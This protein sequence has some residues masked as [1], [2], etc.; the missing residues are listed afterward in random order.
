MIEVIREKCVGCSACL[1]ACAY[2]AITIED[3]LAEID[4]DKCTLCGACVSACPFDA[5]IVRRFT[6]VE[7]NKD[8]YKG[9]WVFAEQRVNDI[10]P[11]VFELLGKGRELADTRE[12]EL[13]AVL[14]GYN[15]KSLADKLIA[16][17]ADKVIIVDEPELEYFTDLA[18]AKAMEELAVKHKPEII[19]SG[20]TNLGRSFIPR[21]AVKLNTGLTADC[22]SLE[23]DPESSNLMQTRPAFGGNIMA[24]ILTP[25]HR[26]QMATVRHKVMD[27]LPLDESRSGTI[28]EEDINF[29]DSVT[30]NN[31][32]E[33]LLEATKGVNLSEANIVVAGGRGLKDAKNFKMIEDLAEA[34]D[35]AVG[36]SRAAVDN[37]WVAYP[38]QVGQTGKTIKPTIYIAIGIS[39][40]IQHLAG[41]QSSDYI[42]AINKDAEA[43]IF[44]VA[45]YGIVGDLFEIVPAIIKQLKG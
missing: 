33:T 17:G 30:K 25:N 38:H 23:I 9:V 39:G 32:I 6:K 34:L 8:D 31:F 11:V 37:E 2:Q 24:T 18:Y 21:V 43:P 3:K 27:P 36:A 14:L 15:V 5:I 41:M 35:G 13:T 20:A 22:T 42:I 44:D 16:G 7:I 19:L 45:D 28:I 29:D 26:P 1:K 12:T 4:A 10:A 40:A